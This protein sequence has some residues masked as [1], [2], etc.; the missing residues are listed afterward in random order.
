[1][2]VR[3]NGTAPEDGAAWTVLS[4]GSDRYDV[5]EV[6]A[7]RGVDVRRRVQVRV[8]RSPRDQ[9]EQ[10][11]GSPY[12]VLWRGRATLRRKLEGVTFPGVHLVG[13]HAAAGAGVPLVGLS[14]AVVAQRVGRA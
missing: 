3:T 13:A 5:V 4:R 14:A 7:R 8:D 6:M 1:L 9:V 11:A 2:V 10:L 12:G